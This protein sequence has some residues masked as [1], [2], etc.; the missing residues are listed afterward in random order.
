MTDDERTFEALPPAR[1]QGF[2][3]TWWGQ[4]WLRAL[5]D[6][7]LE[8]EQLRRGRR[9]ARQGAVGAVTVRPGRITAVVR[10]RDGTPHRS[11]VLVRQLPDSD[12]EL[13]LEVI[14]GEAGH[15]AALLDQDLPP[16]LIEDAANA[17]VELLPGIGELEPECA[18]DAW[19]HCPHTAAL[20]YQV[21]RVLD[22]S[23]LTLL[24][25]RGRGERALLAELQTRASAEPG[26]RPDDLGAVAGGVSAYATGAADSSGRETP[27]DQPG[28]PAEEAFVLGAILPPLPS[29][30]PPVSAPG[31]PPVLSGGSPPPSEAGVDVTALE[32]LAWAAA[33]RA[34]RALGDA[35]TPEHARNPPEAPLT[36]AEDAVRLAALDPE[37]RIAARL[38]SG[39][40]RSR[41]GLDRAVRA[42]KFG[43]RRAL[44]VLEGDW[45]PSAEASARARAQVATAWP[46]AEGRPALRVDGSH[47][48]VVGE[49]VQLRYGPRGRWWPYRWEGG[50]W[51]PAGSSEADPA[52][53]LALLRT[54]R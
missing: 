8:A 43:G 26:K 29:L 14:T 52:T 20:S 36:P 16:R 27:A 49:E 33:V 32:F 48:T 4:A 41:V 18:C 45:R 28:V 46:E 1:G 35:L 30:P 25:L 12:W 19:D 23:P 50:A 9:H 3:R 6:T 40:G 53:A 24:L 54:P 2:A 17:G 13:L 7:A 47:W 37:E 11:D 39:S 44:A 22:Q 21:A 51:W 15:L 10:D 34:H 38:A 5:E 42:W 31:R